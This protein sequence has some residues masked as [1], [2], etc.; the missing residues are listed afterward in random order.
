MSPGLCAIPPFKIIH[1]DLE[2]GQ[3]RL[4]PLNLD[5][6]A[7]VRQT[8]GCVIVEQDFHRLNARE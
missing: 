8:I 3:R 7:P 5:L 6:R 4:R 2:I 1:L